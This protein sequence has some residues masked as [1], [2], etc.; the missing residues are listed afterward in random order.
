MVSVGHLFFPPQRGLR[1]KKEFL[2]ISGLW[3]HK[4]RRNQ[5]R[6]AVWLHL[7]NS[8]SMTGLLA[9]QRLQPWREMRK[10]DDKH[11]YRLQ[12][13]WF[14][15]ALCSSPLLPYQENT[16]NHSQQHKGHRDDQCNQSQQRKKITPSSIP[17]VSPTSRTTKESDGEIRIIM[18][19]GRKGRNHQ[20]QIQDAAVPCTCRW[21]RGSI[22]ENRNRYRRSVVGNS[23]MKHV[24]GGFEDVGR[25]ESEGGDVS[26]CRLTDVGDRWLHG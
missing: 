5:K 3:T 17:S 6:E 21:R 22:Q 10:G 9:S 24:D 15:K 8:I 12:I 25:E 14:L 23:Q 18:E 19:G 13:H 26:W 20:F 4:T 11:Y 1:L 16:N 7:T 2:S